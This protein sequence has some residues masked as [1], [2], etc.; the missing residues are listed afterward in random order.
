MRDDDD[1]AKED[2]KED[3]QIHILTPQVE[4]R[5]KR[6]GP[7]GTHHWGSDDSIDLYSQSL[8]NTV[9]HP[10]SGSLLRDLNTQLYEL[11]VQ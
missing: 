4:V 1:D 9:S 3:F 5:S 10:Y 8:A 7:Y 11:S 6:V 2:L